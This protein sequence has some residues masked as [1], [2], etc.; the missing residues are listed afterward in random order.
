MG[1]K[2]GKETREYK[3]SK[4]TPILKKNLDAGIKA[5]ANK[6]GTIFVDHSVD[7]NSKQGKKIIYHEMQHLKDLKSGK[8]DYG[9]DY[10][11][12]GGSTY[13]RENGKINY[14]GKLY[15]EGDPNL[16]WE[17]VAINAEKNV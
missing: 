3:S 7:L 11:R 14:N 4:N 6:D 8:S 2:L 17:K 13:A 1:F 12:W 5:E 15:D 10:V 9:E 16:P